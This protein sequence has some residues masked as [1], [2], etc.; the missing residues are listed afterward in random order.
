MEIN[1][2]KVKVKEYITPTIKKKFTS[3]EKEFITSLYNQKK[4]WS[5]RQV[6][7]FN[8]IITKYKLTKK[9][10]KNKIQILEP[11]KTY[12]NFIKVKNFDKVKKLTTGINRKNK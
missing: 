6:E 1:H 3:W 4:D 8:N 5:T 2:N 12:N 10:V 11:S 7:V 9:V